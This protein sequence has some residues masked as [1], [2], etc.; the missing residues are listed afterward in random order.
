M[1]LLKKMGLFL[2]RNYIK[3]ITC[4]CSIALL[5][6]LFYNCDFKTYAT[7]DD[8][9][10]NSILN[11][12]Q[13]KVYD[14]VYKNIMD[15][16]ENIFKLASPLSHDN[17]FITMNAV[18]NDHPE[19]FWVST[20]YK[21]GYN[22]AGD[23]VQLKLNY[24]IPKN[25]L[26]SASSAFNNSINRIV[27]QAA[28]YPTD[29]ERERAVHDMICDYATYSTDSSSHQSAYSAIVEGNSVCAGYSRAF[30]IA[31]RKLGITCYYVTGIANGEEHAWNIVRIGGNYYNVDIT[32]DDTINETLNTH[33][34]TYFNVSD[35]E[36]AH[37]HVRSELSALLPPCDAI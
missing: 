4:V 34:Y 15:F 7:G 27:T 23:V 2:C 36:I 8:Y 6:T 12:N 3:F 10:Y 24:C 18:Y 21:Y 37:N 9:I 1:K 19:L 20:S 11:A 22:A 5:F 32:G 31:C 17:L 28:I 29:L 30:Q 33:S 16:N 14:Q 13:K 26:D 35:G 25:D